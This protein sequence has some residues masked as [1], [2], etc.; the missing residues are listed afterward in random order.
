MIEMHAPSD[1]AKSKSVRGIEHIDALYSYAMILTC[2]RTDAEELVQQT[3]IRAM[4][5]KREGW[6]GG[7]GRSCLFAL[8]RGIW[9]NR[10]PKRRTQHDW[11]NETANITA[12]I[13]YDPAFCF[14][15]IRRAV[16]RAALLRLPLMLR[17][18]MLLREYEALSCKQ[19]ATILK[20]RTSTVKSLLAIA[21]SEL[22]MALVVQSPASR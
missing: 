14:K 19:V 18:V 5:T 16:M 7:N 10:S 3:Y 1:D 22:Q 21:R 12:K 13:S 20:C 4:A 17:E 9:L 6:L 15:N 2:N 8:L 11:D